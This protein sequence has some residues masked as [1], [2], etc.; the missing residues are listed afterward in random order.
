MLWEHG[1]HVPAIGKIDEYSLC[2]VVNVVVKPEV[3]TTLM[4]CFRLIRVA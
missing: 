4:F 3:T 1:I 2:S